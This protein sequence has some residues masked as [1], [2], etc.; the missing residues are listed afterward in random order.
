VAYRHEQENLYIFTSGLTAPGSG[1]AQ[2]IDLPNRS[3]PKTFL[4]AATVESINTNV[5]VRLD[6]SLDGTNYAPIVTGQTITANGT[7]FYSVTD[8]PVKYIQPVFVSESG[9]TAAVV[10]FGISATV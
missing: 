10:T 6:G 8:R 9:G 5:V 2:R 7:S 4:F 3:A 1:D